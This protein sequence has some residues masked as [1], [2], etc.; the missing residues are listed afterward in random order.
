M[1]ILTILLVL[2]IVGLILWLVNSYIPMEP[3]IK[4]ILNVT[5]IIL[6]IVWLLKAVGFWSYLVSAHV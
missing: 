6:V 2:I 5:V 1:S 3:T 4:R